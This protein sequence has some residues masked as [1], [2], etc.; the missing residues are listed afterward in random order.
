MLGSIHRTAISHRC[1][2]VRF[3]H[4]T[5]RRDDTLQN[6]L[7][8]LL[9]NKRGKK[10]K[11]KDDSFVVL[12]PRQTGVLKMPRRP[13]NANSNTNIS[14]L[15]GFDMNRHRE[16]STMSSN[17]SELDILWNIKETT[18]KLMKFR[19][20]ESNEQLAK[21]IESCK[22][23]ST[24][25][26]EERFVQLEK[27]L[28]EQFTLQQLKLYTKLRYAYYRSRITKQKLIPMV[29][30]KFWNCTVD[31]E[32]SELEDLIVENEIS[33]E[34]RDIYLLLLTKNGRI[35]QN[36]ARIGATIAVVI[37]ENKIIVR[38]TS[39]IFK[40]V[41]V[42]ISKI[43]SNIQSE[44]ISVDQIIK[45]HSSVLNSSRIHPEQILSMVQ[46]ESSTFVEP[47]ED[48]K[49]KI[50]AI[51][52]KNLVSI[53]RLLL[54]AL[55]Y[56]PQT[57]EV[58]LFC[59]DKSKSY[60]RY[61]L[62]NIEWLDWISKTDNWFRLQEPVLRSQSKTLPMVDITD[63][64]NTLYESLGKKPEK[65]I[66]PKLSNFS[67]TLSATLGQVLENQTG[68][69][70]FQTKLGNLL[71]KLLQLPLWSD[72]SNDYDAYNLDHHVYLFQ[73]KFSPNIASLNYK[74]DIPP[75]ELWFTVDDYG[76]ADKL[77]LR[78][79][80]HYSEN[81]A[82]LQ[83]PELPYDFRFSLDSTMDTI[84]LEC[85]SKNLFEWILQEQPGLAEFLKTL[86]LHYDNKKTSIPQKLVLKMPMKSF[87]IAQEINYDFLALYRHRVLRFKYQDKY[88]VQ[89]SNI[90]GGHLGG[91]TSRVDFVSF[92]DT[93]DKNLLNEMITD[94]VKF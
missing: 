43:L 80:H 2:I 54:W 36:L 85:D 31:P 93:F 74:Y 39:T 15:E 24:V 89:Y 91:T 55:N 23:S 35:L 76:L 71:P 62:T 44:V 53:N 12:T 69:H 10:L 56:S 49:Y 7:T 29:I 27:I 79:I 57:T 88:L 70:L 61:P 75:L 17:S 19:E 28:D 8:S 59:G 40:Y 11:P 63:K 6:N 82:I 41:E 67:T 78:C 18:D 52:T 48:S 34:T 25:I 90:D 94:I 38:S 42:S 81:C 83:T 37:D 86:H 5:L 92:N 73:L 32:K 51:G 77:S 45:D 14:I 22:P 26:S 68:K 84:P 20:Q 3:F 30:K 33:L 47:A 65:M 50:S 72:E 21:T 60:D 16:K 4:S 46:R 66:E 13:K 58:L 64:I 87:D 9:L 1:G